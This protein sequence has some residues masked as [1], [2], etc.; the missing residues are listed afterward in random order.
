MR[1]AVLMLQ[2]R[3]LLSQG[4]QAIQV[5]IRPAQHQ[6]HLLSKQVQ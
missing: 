4:I 3:L 2:G 5:F 6:E 1:A